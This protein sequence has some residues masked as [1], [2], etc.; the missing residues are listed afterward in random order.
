MLG[1]LALAEDLD[2]CAGRGP[3]RPRGDHDQG[4]AAVGDHAAVEPVQRVADHRRVQDLLDGDRVAEQGV[5]VVLGVLARRHLDLGQLGAGGAELVHVA[6]GGQGVL[7]GGGQPE[8]ASKPSR[9]PAL[10]PR[11][12]GGC[13]RGGRPG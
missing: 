11:R 7:G 3:G 8:G 2:R 13:E 1:R 9:A 10:A 6:P 4:A 12:G 5:G